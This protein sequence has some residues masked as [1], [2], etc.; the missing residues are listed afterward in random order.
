VPR[1]VADGSGLP[2]TLPCPVAGEQF[3]EATARPAAAHNNAGASTYPGS[4]K[5]CTPSLRNVR[6]VALTGDFEGVL[7]VG[8][9]LRHRAVVHTFTLANP[10]R[11]VIDVGR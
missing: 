9:G 1:L 11:M 10:T 8:L 5:F 3:L 4:R 6:A 7:T 2:V